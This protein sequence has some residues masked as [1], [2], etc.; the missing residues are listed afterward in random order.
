MFYEVVYH[1]KMGYAGVI[2]FMGYVNV[3][4]FF[5]NIHS[6]CAG[7]PC[8]PALKEKSGS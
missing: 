4:I 7:L 3:N 1:V 6:L 2:N 8:V 5:F